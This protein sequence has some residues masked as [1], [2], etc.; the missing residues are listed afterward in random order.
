MLIEKKHDSKTATK[1]LLLVLL[2]ILACFL[3]SNAVNFANERVDSN[4]PFIGGRYYISDI[5]TYKS[6]SVFI[7][8]NWIFVPNIDYDLIDSG[9]Y[10]YWDYNSVTYAT[11]VSISSV[12]GWNNL[13]DD[14]VWHN[15]GEDGVV[16]NTFEREGKTKKAALYVATIVFDDPGDTYYLNIPESCGLTVIYCNGDKLGTLW[17]REGEWAPAFGYGYFQVPII[18]DSNGIARVMIAVSSD[19]R[20]FNPGLSAYPSITNSEVSAKYTI[21]PSIW[22]TL[23]LVLFFFVLVGG[24]MISRTFKYR[25]RYYLLILLEVLILIYTVVDCHFVSFSAIQEEMLSYILLILMDMIMYNFINSFFLS[26]ELE[27]REKTII[28]L[29]GIP[30]IVTGIILILSVIFKTS[31]LGTTFPIVSSIAFEIVITILCGLNMLTIYYHNTSDLYCMII[32]VSY[33]FFYVNIYAGSKGIYNL[34]TY[35]IFFFIANLTMTFYYITRYIIQERRLSDTIDHMQYLVHE[36]TL[37]I[38]E[39]NKDL[40]NTNKRLLENEQAR[41]NVL[42]NVSHDLR[43]P[44]TAIR[45]YAELLLTSGQKMSETQRE[46]YLQNIIRRAS[47][48]ERIISDIVDLTR[49]ESGANEFQFTDVSISELLDEICMMYETDLANTKKRLTLDIPEDDLLFVRAD[50]KKLSRVFENLISNAVN[51]TF[52]E[53]EIKVKAWRENADKE[54]SEQTVH[55]TVSDNGI[56]IPENEI[57]MVFDRF[58]RAK[59]SGGNIKG[60][61]IGLSIVKTIIDRH[62]ATITVESTIGKGTTFHVTMKATY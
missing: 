38:S 4:V 58:Y 14:V 61:G 42:S 47:Q 48:M 27:G 21:I 46:N 39:I 6:E 51:Y 2:F 60:T 26:P 9:N 35:S 15:V 25:R 56:G 22:L 17:D 37:H 16:F 11:G 43:T 40:Y 24:L 53:A 19:A 5:E 12:S 1:Q 44:I 34:P 3:L 62:D 57:P 55:I 49:L 28:R 45:G 10:G 36:K 13:G 8:S 50:P 31:L 30:V 23:Q 52:E 59:N 7:G 54:L 18:P 33:I 41:K 20:I 32:L 29:S